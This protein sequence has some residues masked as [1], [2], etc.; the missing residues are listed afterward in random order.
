MIMIDVSKYVLA[1]VTPNMVSRGRAPNIARGKKMFLVLFR[2]LCRMF[3][4]WPRSTTMG[5]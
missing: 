2:F 3:P 4:V 5:R 1:C